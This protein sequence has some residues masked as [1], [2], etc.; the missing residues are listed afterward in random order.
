MLQVCGEGEVLCT[1]VFF[2]I[3]TDTGGWGGGDNSGFQSLLVRSVVA[4]FFL[5]DRF[6]SQ[7]QFI[8]SRYMKRELL[9]S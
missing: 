5:S 8:K 2:D 4:L 9:S 1:T 6:V 3:S 7:K